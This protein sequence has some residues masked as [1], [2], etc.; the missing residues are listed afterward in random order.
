M[1]EGTR[2]MPHPK[3]LSIIIPAYNEE[4][5]ITAL[6]EKSHAALKTVPD[7][8]YEVI[9]VNDGSTDAT[10][11]KA[12]ATQALVI[13][14]PKNVGYG[15]SILTGID[16]ATHDLIAI[17]DADG[18]YDPADLKP[19]IPLMSVYEMVI[20]ARELR[21]QSLPVQLLR[22]LLKSIILYFTGKTSPDPNSG[23]RIFTKDLVRNGKHLFSQKFSFSTSL[24]VYASLTHRF[25]EYL[26]I[27]YYDR[28]GN[29]KVRHLRDSIRTFFLILSMALVFQPGKCFLA[30]GVIFTLGLLALTWGRSLVGIEGFMT[31]GIVWMSLH[32]MTS[33]AFLS[34][35]LSCLYEQ[36]SRNR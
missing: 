8:A 18:T 6:V 24:T 19:M 12:Q 22:L 2:L 5:A 26:P 32:L 33:L 23:L 15:R 10:A 14:H 3:G 9:I 30:Q 31:W 36:T 28:T 35:L 7:L 21:N 1:S 27:P 13:N 16:H 25:I 4:A 17:I 11:E 34:H 20:G 29:S